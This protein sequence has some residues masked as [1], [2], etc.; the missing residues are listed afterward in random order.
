[1]A[2]PV[3]NCLAIGIVAI[4][5]A[6]HWFGADVMETLDARFKLQDLE[7]LEREIGYQGFFRLDKLVLKHRLFEGGWSAPIKRELFIRDDA[8]CILLYDPVKDA[9]V[10]IEQFRIGCLKDP[11]SP[12]LLEL[13]AG[14]IEPG[15]S[16]EEVA[17]RESQEEAGAE[18]LDLVHI[19]NYHVSPG[20]SQEYVHLMCAKVDSSGIG[21]YHGLEHEGE[22]IRVTVVP[23]QKAY[24][25]VESNRINNA[26]TI[27][28]LQWLQ[29]NYDQL[30]SR[31]HDDVP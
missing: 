25:A 20:G 26:P 23:R 31:W 2:E 1:M 18:I 28:A 27:I 6:S 9:V 22:D 24:A 30:R 12:W 14:I 13:I 8:A 17:R 11:T 4:V 19:C 5:P 29:L 21:G 16:D 10:L 7:I 3:N 15:E